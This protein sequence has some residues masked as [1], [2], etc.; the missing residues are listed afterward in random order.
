L[1]KFSFNLCQKFNTY[2]HLYSILGAEK[3]DFK[4]IRILAIHY[5]KEVL[6]K[7]FSLLGIPQPERM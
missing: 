6:K 1:A 7:A 2:Y 3:T 4:K 5:T